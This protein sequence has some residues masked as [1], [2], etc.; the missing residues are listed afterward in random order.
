MVV[1]ILN[2]VTKD[3]LPKKVLLKWRPEVREPVMLALLENLV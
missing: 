3:D 2:K 1:E